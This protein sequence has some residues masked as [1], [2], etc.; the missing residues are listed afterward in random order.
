MEPAFLIADEAVSALDVSVQMQILNMLL[1]LRER[2]GVSIIFI[3]HDI[4]VVDYICDR[5]MVVY[6]GEVVESGKK[7]AVLDHPENEYTRKLISAVPQITSV[8]LL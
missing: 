6:G 3:T 4:S 5:V 2:I 7:N 8:K 1:D